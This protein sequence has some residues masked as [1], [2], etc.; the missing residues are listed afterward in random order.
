MRRALFVLT[1][2]PWLAFAGRPSV[3]FLGAHPDDT[4]GF[5]GLA[6]LLADDYE[7]HVVDLTRGELG[8]GPEGLADGSTAVTR[9]REEENACKLL[10]AHVH[11]LGE[12][13]GSACASSNAVAR[14]AEI[15][16]TTKPVAVFT[17]WPLDAHA[18]HMQC[19]AVMANAIRTS[20]IK[21]EQYFYE[22]L[23]AQTRYWNP[24]Y[25]V[26]I[27]TVMDRKVELLRCYACQ[28]KDDEIV[29]EKRKQAESRGRERT[30]QVRYAETFTTF[31]GK[32]WPGILE[33]MPQTVRLSAAKQADRDAN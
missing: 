5:A 17:H 7:L 8:L 9:T 31:D 2:L 28:N 3:V 6:F 15:L 16:T 4:E 10:G 22:V 19:A 11:F 30:P 14:L 23:Q 27:T 13:D 29:R 32:P 24:L 1:L 12:T 33:K 25:S 21:P 18:D 26:D 20:G